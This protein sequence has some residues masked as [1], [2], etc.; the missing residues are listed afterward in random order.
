MRW[1]KPCSTYETL[2][3]MISFGMWW[4]KPCSTVAGTK[5][6]LCFLIRQSNVG[7]LGSLIVTCSLFAQLAAIPVSSD[8]MTLRSFS[9]DVCLFLRW[10][11]ECRFYYY[12]S[13]WA[14]FLPA[15]E[16]SGIIR[17]CTWIGL[18]WTCSTLSYYPMSRAV[19][20]STGSFA[21]P[22]KFSGALKRLSFQHHRAKRVF[23]SKKFES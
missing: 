15:Q 18:G 3:L 5:S 17:N 6:S 7:V 11:N 4:C 10:G 12:Y 21:R 22:M 16:M 2:T 23:G 13:T 9:G 20:G 19:H 8:V 1:C 14:F